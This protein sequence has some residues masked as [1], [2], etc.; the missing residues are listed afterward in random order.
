MEAFFHSGGI[1][2]LNSAVATILQDDLYVA[3][4]R[5]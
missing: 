1:E 3:P 4:L 2:S 5:A